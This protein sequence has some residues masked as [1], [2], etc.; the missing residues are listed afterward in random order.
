M[1]NKT[2]RYEWND[3]K[4]RLTSILKL[5]SFGIEEDTCGKREVSSNRK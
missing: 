2:L 3:E 1:N 4:T 5:A